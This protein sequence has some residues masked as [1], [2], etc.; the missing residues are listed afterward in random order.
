MSVEGPGIQHQVSKLYLVL[1]EFAD[2]YFGE[3]EAAI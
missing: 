1:A 3:G 2:T